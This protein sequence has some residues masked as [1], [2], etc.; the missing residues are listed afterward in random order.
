MLFYVIME[1]NNYKKFMLLAIEE[2]KLAAKNKF[3]PARP[4]Y[5]S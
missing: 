2:A 5:I 4:K 1:N 3:I